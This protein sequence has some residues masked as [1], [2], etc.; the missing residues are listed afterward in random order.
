MYHLRTWLQSLQ[1][2]AR[3]IANGFR[4]LARTS[5]STLPVALYS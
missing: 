4:F 1:S 3:R 2:L 5:R